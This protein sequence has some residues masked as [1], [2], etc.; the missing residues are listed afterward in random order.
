VVVVVVLARA[1]SGVRQLT[2]PAEPMPVAGTITSPSG[3]RNVVGGVGTVVGA[4]PAPE[5]LDPEFDPHPAR[6]SPPARMAAI[7]PASFHR[8]MTYIVG[9]VVT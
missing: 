2:S 4:R 5:V 9:P 3:H 8:D 6:G 1:C 7:A